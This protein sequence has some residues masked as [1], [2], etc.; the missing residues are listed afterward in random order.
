MVGI[1]ENLWTVSDILTH[2]GLST[3]EVVGVGETSSEVPSIYWGMEKQFLE[4][5]LYIRLSPYLADQISLQWRLRSEIWPFYSA[6][7]MRPRNR[8]LVC[9]WVGNTR[10]CHPSFIHSTKIY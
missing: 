4:H 6:T 8:E 9:S 10:A 3:Q 7:G 1:S 2:T 5:S